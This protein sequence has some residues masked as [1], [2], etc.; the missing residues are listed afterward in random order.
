MI[1]Q[2]VRSSLRLIGNG[3]A[4]GGYY[5]DV[6]VV[7]DGVI[8]GDFDCIN[9]RS[10]GN[11]KIN[12]NMVTKSVRIAGSSSVTGSLK[13]DD[14]RVAGN[15]DVLGDIK[16][17][18][19]VIRG[20]TEAKGNIKADDIGIKGYMTVKKNCE[21]ETFKSEGP[22]AIGGLL[23][24]EQ[25][26][27]RIHSTC[28]ATEIGGETISARRGHGA[29]LGHIIKSLFLPADF[30]NGKLVAD[31]IEGDEIRLEYTKAKVV[32]GSSVTIGPG[33]EIEL[34]EYKKDLRVSGRPLIREKRKIDA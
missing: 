14:L 19:I 21:A 18:N 20:G 15:L 13:S 5:S 23:N 25:V 17:K 30:Y 7:G 2:D 9:F 3:S 1:K 22:I 34:V 10:A 32:R 11:S 12:G 27:I 29:T 33:C 4:S 16:S 8:N 31:S 26:D 24:A 28:S 6:K